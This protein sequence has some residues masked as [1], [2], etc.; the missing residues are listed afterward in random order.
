[1]LEKNG[2]ILLVPNTLKFENADML[3]MEYKEK[4]TEK[5]KGKAKKNPE[6]VTCSFHSTHT[7]LNTYCLHHLLL[8][9]INDGEIHKVVCGFEDN[10]NKVPSAVNGGLVK[11]WEV[12][13]V[14][15]YKG[16]LQ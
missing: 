10:N 2:S 7:L 13:S 4:L 6:G 8:R 1:M 5:I 9:I 3:S 15:L 14:P 11:R 16:N 12:I